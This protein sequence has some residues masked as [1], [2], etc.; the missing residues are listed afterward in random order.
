M[1]LRSKSD[2]KVITFRLNEALYL[3]VKRL[4][5]R[6]NISMNRLLICTVADKVLEANKVEHL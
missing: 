6:M 4:A 1:G 2:Q 5:D 3:E